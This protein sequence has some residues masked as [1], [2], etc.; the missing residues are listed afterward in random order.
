MPSSIPTKFN[1][2]AALH[3]D[4]AR[5]LHPTMNNGVTADMLVAGSGRIMVWQCEVDP[6]H[7]YKTK[8]CSRTVRKTGCNICSGKYLDPKNSLAARRPDLIPYWHPTKNGKVGPEHCS[9]GSQ[10][11]VW[12]ICRTNSEHSYKTKIAVRARSYGECKECRSLYVTDENRLSICFPEIAA[13]LHP[14]KNRML[15]ATIKENAQWFPHNQFRPGEEPKR[16]RRITAA[17]IR[18]TTKETFTWLASCGHE[19][20]ASAYNRTRGQGCGICFNMKTMP[21]EDMS[22]AAVYPGVANMWHKSKN[23]SVKPTQ[24]RPNSGKKYHFRCPRHADH[25]FEATVASVVRS[26]KSGTNGCPNCRGLSVIY[27]DSLAARFPKVASM[28][29]GLGNVVDPK[30][31]APRSNKVAKFQCPLKSY[32]VFETTI[33]K[34]VNS[35]KKGRSGCGFCTGMKVHPLDSLAEH[36]PSVSKQIDK[37]KANAPNPRELLPGSH[38]VVAFRCLAP[39]HHKWSAMVMNVVQNYERRKIICPECWAKQDI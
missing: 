27:R 32:H 5:Q 2:L 13:E 31:V 16:N 29:M 33:D 24:V 36:F 4:I 35:S 8:V 3:P 28:M 37:T 18:S 11:K 21:T 39:E 10:Q 20:Q 17:D 30:E 6:T 12:W 34:A 26:W 19:W 9:Y 15:Y 14:T 1:S 7:T 22:L 25:V 38:R 23:G